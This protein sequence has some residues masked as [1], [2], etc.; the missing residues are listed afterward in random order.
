MSLSQLLTNTEGAQPLTVVQHS[1][2]PWATVLQASIGQAKLS[3][4]A[5]VLVLKHIRLTLI[6]VQ[7]AHI[8]QLK[9]GNQVFSLR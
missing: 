6:F 4:C 5:Q 8:W 7:L 9:E 3:K 1:S 2:K